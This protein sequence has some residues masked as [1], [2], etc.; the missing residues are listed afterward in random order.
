MAAMPD[1]F[2]S[3]LLGIVQVLANNE[4]EPG[5]FTKMGE[6]LAKLCRLSSTPVMA[7]A[8]RIRILNR[9]SS[10][11]AWVRELKDV[12]YDAE[13]ILIDLCPRLDLGEDL[14][15][16]RRSARRCRSIPLLSLSCFSKK[17]VVR[18]QIGR[19]I[20]ELNQRLEELVTR[21]TGFIDQAISYWD[22][23]FGCI[24]ALRRTRSFLPISYVVGEK[25]EEDTRKLVQLLVNNEME[26]HTRSDDIDNNVV[27]AAITGAG[28]TGKTTL[29]Q[30]VFND[31]MVVG[32]FEVKIWLSVSQ[33][34]EEPELL[35]NIVAATGGD[36]NIIN[37]ITVDMAMLRNHVKQAVRHKRFLLVMDD[38]W[39]ESVWNKLLRAPLSHGARGSRVLVT[40][41]KDQVAHGMKTQYLHRVTTLNLEDAW[42]LLKTQVSN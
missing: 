36:Y 2:A 37:D 13:D 30:M 10:V 27:V 33:H 28:G 7:F 25:I 29:A 9:D 4:V 15:L 12:M 14:T 20:K 6:T 35:R 34:V 41:R 38:V 18:H 11:G 22:I 17:Q 40:T 19:A 21:S 3:K 26:P 8:E 5:E 16:A 42:I 32:N 31:R 1:A 23:T 24:H 39:S